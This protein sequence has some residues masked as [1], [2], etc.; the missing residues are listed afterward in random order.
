MRSDRYIFHR[1]R[2]F[3]PTVRNLAGLVGLDALRQRAINA[4]HEFT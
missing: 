1:I 2:K 4:V 3:L